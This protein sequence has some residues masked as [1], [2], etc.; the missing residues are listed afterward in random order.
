[1]KKLS[2]ALAMLWSVACS[3]VHAENEI[4]QILFTGK[5]TSSSCIIDSIGTTSVINYDH[6]SIFYILYQNTTSP[7]VSRPFDIKLIS[8]PPDVP[9]KVRFEGPM[10]PHQK[11]LRILQGKISLPLL[12]TKGRTVKSKLTSLSLRRPRPVVLIF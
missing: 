4:G 6:V 12:L 10:M 3:T 2:V 7:I 1:M 9:I 11:P 8:C 5:V